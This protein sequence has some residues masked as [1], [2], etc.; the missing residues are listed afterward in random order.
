MGHVKMM[1]AVQPFLSG[2]I[3]K[4]VNLPNSATVEDIKE[5]YLQG[6]KLGLKAVALYRDG[7]KMSQPLSNTGS[8]E[9]DEEVEPTKV[10]KKELMWG[11][12]KK[13]P[14][15]RRGVTISS[16]V[17]PT[18][19]HLRTGEYADGTLGE[20]FVDSFKEGASYRGLLNCFAVA[21]SI[22]LQHGVPLEEYVNAFTFTRFEPSGMTNHPNIKT[23]TSM[24]DYIFRVLGMEYLNRTDFVHIKPEKTEFQIKEDQKLK[25]SIGQ[26]MITEQ[27]VSEEVEATDKTEPS[28]ISNSPDSFFANLM[29][30]APACDLCGHITVR[31]GACY[32]CTNCGNSMGC[33]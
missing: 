7:C 29:G 17:G 12:Q 22:G 15:K 3:S 13:L 9:K 24:V 27:T 28:K 14:Q 30:D 16:K 26:A 11:M 18:K 5:I 10:Q 32:K 4:T 20:I 6:W 23:C 8:T 1:A 2:A 33:S 31:N 25:D 19:I 21:T